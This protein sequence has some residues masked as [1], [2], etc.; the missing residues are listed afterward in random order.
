MFADLPDYEI[1]SRLKASNDGR[2]SIGLYE[3]MVQAQQMRTTQWRMARWAGVLSL[4]CT[5]GAAFIGVVTA[6]VSFAD[7]VVATRVLSILV[8]GFGIVL[9]LL[10]GTGLPES[11]L[12]DYKRADQ[13]IEQ[14]RNIFA[15][16]P[17]AKPDVTKAA[18][19]QA[20]WRK[21]RDDNILAQSKRWSSV[22][23]ASPPAP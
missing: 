3:V 18:E 8:A 11:A 23:N 5:L 17:G 2:F 4:V 9:S 20:A 7:N 15:T 12:E 16:E 19:I 14:I 13:I 10:K 6:I 22:Q 1:E 21:I